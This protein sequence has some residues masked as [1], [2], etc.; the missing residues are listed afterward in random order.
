VGTEEFAQGQFGRFC[1]AF[2]ARFLAV[3]SPVPLDCRRARVNISG[4]MT[5]PP[6]VTLRPHPIRAPVQVLVVFHMLAAEGPRAPHTQHF[7][8]MNEQNCGGARRVEEL[9]KRF[10]RVT[11]AGFR[12]VQLNTDRMAVT[13]PTSRRWLSQKPRLRSDLRCTWGW[14]LFGQQ[15]HA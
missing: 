2:S 7:K 4:T 15:R 1:L 10:Q 14:F 9:S 8:M 12:T 3:V 6:C 13:P 11:C 5:C